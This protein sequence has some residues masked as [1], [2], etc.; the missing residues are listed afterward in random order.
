MKAKLIITI[1]TLVILTSCTINNDTGTV[2]QS[3]ESYKIAET[4]NGAITVLK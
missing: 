1:L 3:D 2:Y 4:T